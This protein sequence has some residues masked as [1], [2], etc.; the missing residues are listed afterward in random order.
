MFLPGKRYF[1]E[2]QHFFFYWSSLMGWMIKNTANVCMLYVL[3]IYQFVRELVCLAGR[4]VLVENLLFKNSFSPS[5]T[6]LCFMTYLV[7][8]SFNIALTFFAYFVPYL[9]E[10]FNC[11]DYH[12]ISSIQT[13]IHVNVLIIMLAYCCFFLGFYPLFTHI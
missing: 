2:P 4:H 5:W 8:Q 9:I 6:L 11:Y 12:A 13:V 7:N 10:I 3:W 1:N